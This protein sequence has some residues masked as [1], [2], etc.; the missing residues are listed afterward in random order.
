MAPE[1]AMDRFQRDLVRN[2]FTTSTVLLEDA[3]LVASRGQGRR[4]ARDF[5]RL[6]EDLRRF[7]QDVAAASEAIVMISQRADPSP[8][9]R[10]R[11]RR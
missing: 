3:H 5:A 7:G 9:R 6:A 11:S 4:S 2:L 10:R 8:S 1:G